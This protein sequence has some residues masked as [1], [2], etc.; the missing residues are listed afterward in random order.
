[1]KSNFDSQ[2]KA[3]LMWTCLEMMIKVKILLLFH[4]AIQFFMHLT[5]LLFFLLLSWIIWDVR[6]SLAD[7]ILKASFGE[8]DNQPAVCQVIAWRALLRAA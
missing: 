3:V 8:L 1:M 7:P 6:C 4:L 2:A 5:Y